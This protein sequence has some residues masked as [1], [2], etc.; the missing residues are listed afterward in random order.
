MSKCFN[1]HPHEI[2]HIDVNFV[3]L[4]EAVFHR[5]GGAVNLKRQLIRLD[6]LNAHRNRLLSFANF[7]KH[8]ANK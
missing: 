6:H 4:F 5:F 1:V 7:F 2:C 3:P 8:L